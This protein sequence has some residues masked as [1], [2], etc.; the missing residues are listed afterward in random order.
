MAPY[1]FIS[2]SQHDADFTHWLAAELRDA[3]YPVW[4]D[5]ENIPPGSSWPRE[6]QRAVEGCGAMVVVMS[7]PARESEWVERETLLAMD[8]RKPLFIALTDDTPLP[9][10]LINRQF[11]DFRQRPDDALD[12]LTRALASVSLTEPLPPLSQREQERQSPTANERNIF[13]FLEQLP[14]GDACAA[15]ARDLHTWARQSTDAVTFSGK[16]NPAFHA[17]IWLGP[18]GVVIFSVRAY[19]KQP[20]VEVPLQYFKEFPPFDDPSRR[21]DVLAAFNTLMPD[22]EQFEP[23][24]ADKRPNLPLVTAL[25]LDDHLE[26]FKTIMSDIVRDLRAA[27]SS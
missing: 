17:H 26:R 18:G 27:N 19:P 1:I 4:V 24:K 15:V 20:A 16:A 2:H 13:K 3:G 7:R 8:L 10:H 25:A 11:S 21:R 12:K 9:L 22:N 5:I 14:D 23:E 6:I